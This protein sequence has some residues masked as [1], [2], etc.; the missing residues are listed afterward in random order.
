MCGALSIHAFVSQK[1]DCLSGSLLL[2]ITFLLL[3]P[4]RGT[5]QCKQSEMDRP[6]VDADFFKG[7]GYLVIKQFANSAEVERL[8]AAAT[9]IIDAWEPPSASRLLSSVALRTSGNEDF[10]FLLESATQATVFPE[11]GAVDL[12]TEKMFVNRSK[13]HVVRKIGHG[14]HLAKNNAFRDFVSSAKLKDVV[15]ALGWKAPVVT[16]TIYRV[17]PPFSAGVERHQDATFLF[18]EPETCLGMLVAM[19]AFDE[20]NGCVH[21]RPG[22]H[23]EP[24]RERFI[25]S[26]GDSDKGVKLSFKSMS[27][28]I[29]GPQNFSAFLP[30]ALEP[31]DLLLFHGLLDHFSGQ[32]QHPTRSRESF[33]IHIAE[34]EARWSEDNW[35][36][37]PRDERF[38]PLGP[39]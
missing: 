29:L 7:E 22:S 26:D 4:I 10:S 16:Q 18:T 2:F 32:S 11:I 8:R 13:K 35:L 30:I 24:L 19:E 37:Y 39:A 5:E 9:G 3:I 23:V 21:V 15:V 33:Q 20:R 1:G 38:L 17:T 36:Q 6:F 31:G 27:G 14:L 34:A 12:Q 25:R 28:R